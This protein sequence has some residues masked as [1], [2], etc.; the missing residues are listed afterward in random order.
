VCVAEKDL[1]GSYSSDITLQ[2]EAARLVFGRKLDVQ[3][4]ITHQFP[5]AETAEAV[6]LAANPGR[7]SL[8][9]VVNQGLRCEFL[10]GSDGLRQAGDGGA[11]FVVKN[12]VQE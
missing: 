1:I 11:G 2:R 4:L 6:R 3:G 10:G 7:T 12:S 8:K 5:L 9:V